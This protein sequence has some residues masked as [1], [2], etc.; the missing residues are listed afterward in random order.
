[1]LPKTPNYLSLPYSNTESFETIR[2]S[3]Y[4]ST[5]IADNF[6]HNNTIANSLINNRLD[7]LNYEK[8]I[9]GKISNP[10]QPPIIPHYHSHN[11]LAGCGHHIIHPNYYYYDISIPI[12]LSLI[13][14]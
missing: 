4:N 6:L 5:E 9:L 11:H 1:M 7:K 3:N 13:H 12:Y 2:S 10:Y 14:I 8:E